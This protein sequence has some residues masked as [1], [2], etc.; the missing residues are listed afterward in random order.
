M[1]RW[2][3]FRPKSMLFLNFVVVV[4][5][6]ETNMTMNCLTLNIFVLHRFSRKVEK[7]YFTSY[8]GVY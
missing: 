6:L 1:G 3:G 5:F 4:F 8:L 7:K 2:G